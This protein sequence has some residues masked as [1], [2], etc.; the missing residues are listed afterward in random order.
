MLAPCAEAAYTGWP[1][2]HFAIQVIG[3]P[4][5]SEPRARSKSSRERGC[6]RAKRS[7]SALWTA[8]MRRRSIWVT[9]ATLTGRLAD[10]VAQGLVEVGVA[11]GVAVLEGA[12]R[13][14]ALPG[15]D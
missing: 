11:E 1:P 10:R 6:S 14:R 5:T 2:T 13:H 15:R 4:P 7:P 3:T 9:G 8:A 12:H